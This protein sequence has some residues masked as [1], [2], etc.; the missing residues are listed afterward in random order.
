M[1]CRQNCCK[2]ALAVTL[3][4]AAQVNADPISTDRP[5]F[6][7]SSDVVGRGH[8]QV[9]IGSA[10]QRFEENG[11]ETRTSTT[12][13]LLRFGLNDSMELRLE[14]DNA[15]TEETRKALGTFVESGFG[16][17]SLGVKWHVADAG[18]TAGMPGIALLLHTEIDSGSAAFRGN[19]YRPSF[20][21][22]TEWDLGDTSIGVMPGVYYDKSTLG[23]FWYGIMAV[24]VG[25]QLTENLRGFVEVAGQQ[26][27]STKNGG[28]VVTYDLGLAYLINDSLQAD[29]MVSIG[30]NDN[31][32]DSLGVGISRRF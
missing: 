5:D 30:A 25:H 18:E 9:E 22:V 7:E 14:T 11:V 23:R 3:L 20:R 4:V 15:I 1:H 29:V 19:G 8:F 31:S 2:A 26:I 24:T 16:D 13:T 21:L 6:V 28:K 17:V 12:P 27:A 10:W 32:G